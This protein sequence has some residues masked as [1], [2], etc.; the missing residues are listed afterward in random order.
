V[1]RG[2]EAIVRDTRRVLDMDLKAPFANLRHDVL[3]AK[4]AKRS[5]DPDVRHVLKLILRI[6]GKT[7]VAH[8]DGLAPLLS[9]LS[10]TA[11]DR[12]FERANAVTRRGKSPSLESARFAEDIVIWIDASPQHD[13]LLGAVGTRLR[14]ALARL[15]GTRNEAKSRIVA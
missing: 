14:E 7:G 10:L 5:N 13:G 6:T 15:H 3:L 12:M 11:G 1:E 8:G 2:A 4:G 9:N